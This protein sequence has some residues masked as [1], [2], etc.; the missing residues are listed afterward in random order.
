MI[1]F[2]FY[3]FSPAGNT[4]VFL[5]IPDDGN[6][7]FYGATELN[8]ELRSYYC[9]ESLNAV[10]GEQAAL[11]NLS[12]NYFCM[13]DG[14]FCGNAC[15]AFGALLALKEE[16]LFKNLKEQI[17]DYVKAYSA[18][19]G[20]FGSVMLEVTGNTPQWI[21][22][23]I[24]PENKNMIFQELEKNHVLVSMGGITH[25]LVNC[26][27]LPDKDTGQKL[28]SEKLN[29]FSLKPDPAAGIIWWTKNLRN[30]I[31]IYPFVQTTSINCGLPESS[32]AS[33][34]LALAS[35]LGY[36]EPLSI[37]QPSGKFL[38]INLN[39]SSN[40]PE[41]A[42][43]YRAYKN[44][45]SISGPVELAAVGQIWLPEFIS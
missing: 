40:N 24:L 44:K 31:E 41:D 14:E 5:E 15:R 16:R 27:A 30:Q 36:S 39:E 25:L 28:F 19:L 43:D 18:S 1:K 38:N 22:K 45:T 8:P 29:K 32:C 10:G 9:K 12:K 7:N 17:P 42:Q 23:V 21:V 3:K 20:N 37:L 35:F 33:G 11:T 13:G 4:T 26:D 6:E 34:S 2:N